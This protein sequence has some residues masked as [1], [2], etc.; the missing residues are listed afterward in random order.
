MTGDHEHRIKSAPDF[1]E[2][3]SAHNEARHSLAVQFEEGQIDA[4]QLFDML[5]SLESAKITRWV[6][7][8]EQERKLAEQTQASQG[9]HRLDL[10]RSQ[11]SADKA[12]EL[13]AKIIDARPADHSEL[14]ALLAEISAAASQLEPPDYAIVYLFAA[15]VRIAPKHEHNN[16]PPDRTRQRRSTL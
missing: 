3:Q 5:D 1:T 9:R 8:A 10:E 11:A 6:D 13:R 16:D 14:S 4:A 12:A 2:L 7:L 15:F